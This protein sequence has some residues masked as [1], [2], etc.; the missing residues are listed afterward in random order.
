MTQYYSKSTKNM[1]FLIFY[2]STILT[3][4][5]FCQKPDL[6][7]LSVG[8]SDYQSDKIS[9]LK[10]ADK[11]AQDLAKA[12]ANQTSL[13]N[14]KKSLVLNNQ[15]ATVPAVRQ[16]FSEFSEMITP[17]DFFIFIF[18]GHGTKDGTLATHEIDEDNP[19]A[20]SLANQ[21]LKSLIKKNIVSSYMVLVDACYSRKLLD[22]G[23]K[24][25][26]TFAH[27][28]QVIKEL[29]SALS[30]R[31]KSSIVITSSSSD[32]QSFECSKCENGFFTQSI[33]D[34]LDG[35]PL[36]INESVINPDQNGLI[37]PNSL[38]EYMRESVLNYTKAYKDK[39]SVWS[40]LTLSN[41]FPIAKLVKNPEPPLP[42]KPIVSNDTLPNPIPFSILKK[43][44]IGK[45]ILFPGLGDNKI[46]KH[47]KRIWMGIVGYGAIAGGFIA[48]S[49]SNSYL[50]AY[51]FSKKQTDITQNRNN[52]TK[53]NSISTA[54]WGLSGLIWTI[55]IGGL[56]SLKK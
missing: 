34:A 38:I 2:L 49:K 6:F 11:D 19:Y 16:A 24:D 53:L 17:D 5:G 8:V 39:Q 45:S 1:K 21:E 7:I 42:S 48:Q 55:D 10:F 46:R 3:F 50:N 20:T 25:L 30:D 44:A 4:S 56:L 28:E 29:N 40:N 43:Q 33:L 52:T 26:E 54:L 13:F 22:E 9:D 15:N 18:S 32:K 23:G 27:H 47:S 14:V 51:N 12:F 41:P 35:K 31:D 36:K 37:Y